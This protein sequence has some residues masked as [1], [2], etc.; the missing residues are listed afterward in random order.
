[1]RKRQTITILILFVLTSTSCA[2]WGGHEYGRDGH[3][4]RQTDAAKKYPVNKEVK[5]PSEGQYATA[6]SPAR[7]A[8]M[9]M[10]ARGKKLLEAGDYDKALGIFQEAVI[11]DSTNGVAYYYLAKARFLLD[12]YEESMGILEKAESLLG[13]SEEWME[14]ISLLR[15]QIQNSIHHPDIP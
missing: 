9:E 11:I 13:S 2:T 12:Q 7:S 15:S 6:S 3:Q 8:S 14:A 4:A 5:K 10:A 1:M